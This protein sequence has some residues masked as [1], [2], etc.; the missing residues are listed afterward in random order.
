MTNPDIRIGVGRCIYGLPLLVLSAFLTGCPGQSWLITPVTSRRELT[1][2]RI[3]R[4]A[5]PALDKVAVIDV[6]GIIRNTRPARL[7]GE[8]EQPV[9]LLAEELD[10]ARRDPLVKAVILRI[11]SPGGTVTASELMHDEIRRFR[12]C[13]KPVIAVLMDV[14][15][16]GGYYIACA[17]DEIIVHR[18]T[19]TGS[20]GVIVQ[21]FDISGTMQLVGVK[22]DAIT[23]G[24]RKDSG[25]PFRAMTPEERALFQ[26][27]VNELYDRFVEV[28]REGRPA[29]DETQVRSLA[30]G[31]IYTARQALEAGLVDRIGTWH[32]ALDAARQR[33]GAK[34]VR[35][36]LYHRPLDYR[37]NYYAAAPTLLPTEVNLVGLNVGQALESAAP[38]FLYLWQP[39]VFNVAQP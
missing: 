20:I 2:T 8:G 29:L 12:K 23:S 33:S 10:K 34:R 16:S 15:A 36:V 21:M 35:A 5:W 4:D 38:E 9:S 17:C 13:G 28:V 30:D 25:S 27:V 7:L 31:R 24:P 3:H 6:T 11:N 22:S 19:I 1:E 26:Q 14:A 39:G 37:P 18:T 32:D